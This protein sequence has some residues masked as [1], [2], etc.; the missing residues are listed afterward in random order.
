MSLFF[1]GGRVVEERAVSSL[2]WSHGGDSPLSVSSMESQLSLV[3]VYAATRL[4][5]DAVAS[6]PLQQFRK[7]SDGR[8]PMPLAGVFEN[9]STHGT[10]VDWLVRCMTSLLLQGNAYGLRVGGAGLTPSMVEWLNPERMQWFEGRWLYNGKPL[11]QADLLHIPAMVV[12]GER[13]GMSP[14]GACSTTMSTGLETQ[15][16]I[17]EWYKNRAVPGLWFQNVEKTVE[18]EAAAQAKERLRSTLRAGEPFVTGKDWKLDVVKLSAEDAGF[19]AST[20]LTATQVAN[21]FGVPPEM[22]GGESAGSLT[23]STVELNQIQFLTNALRPWLVRLEAAFSSLLPRPQY[24]KFNV[25]ALIRVDTK[26][27]YDVHRIAREIGLN[28]IDELR[29]LEDM[30]PLPDSLGQDYSPLKAAAPSPAPVEETP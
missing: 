4:I 16:F 6:M 7:A 20:R 11:D 15:R 25:D 10:R 27:R 24:V 2:P 21:I 3:P 1:R 28:N 8:V 18:P 14:I 30:D 17:R 5:A 26:T 29:A 19:V 12:P 13:L 22:I 9:P 23:Y